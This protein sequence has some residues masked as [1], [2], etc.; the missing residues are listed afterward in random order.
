[1]NRFAQ[2]SRTILL[3]LTRNFKFLKKLARQA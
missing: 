3:P 1:M 2:E